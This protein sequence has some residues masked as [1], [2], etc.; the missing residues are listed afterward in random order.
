MNMY[1]T[2]FSNSIF[3]KTKGQTKKIYSFS[4]AYRPLP[5]CTTRSKISYTYS[6]DKFYDVQRFLVEQHR[7]QSAPSRGPALHNPVWPCH[8]PAVRVSGRKPLFKFANYLMIG[9]NRTRPLQFSTA[10]WFP[11]TS[12]KFRLVAVSSHLL[13]LLHSSSTRF[14]MHLVK[15][16]PI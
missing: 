10:S 14:K 8:I 12:T 13:T 7:L 16:Y 5:D 1:S 2:N 3:S 11:I 4:S 6:F 9:Q 15:I